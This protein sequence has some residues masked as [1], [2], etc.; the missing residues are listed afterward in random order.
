[1]TS[2]GYTQGIVDWSHSGDRLVYMVS[3]IGSQG[4]YDL[5]MMNSDGTENRNITPDY[6]PAQFL[7][8]TPQFSLDDS[9]IYFVGEWWE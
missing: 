9:A 5:Y 1:M 8:Y 7:C 6:F 3:A 4:V 2:N